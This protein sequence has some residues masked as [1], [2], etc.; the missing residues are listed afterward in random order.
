M[1]DFF[2]SVAT[3]VVVTVIAGLVLGALAVARVRARSAVPR[4]RA[5][6]YVRWRRFRRDPGPYTQHIH[7]KGI[8][9]GG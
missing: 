8:K 3:E 4:W 1:R 5:T 9:P 2:T 7:P 6:A